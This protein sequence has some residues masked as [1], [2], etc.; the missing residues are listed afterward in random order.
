MP[1][2]NYGLLKAIRAHEISSPRVTDE[3]ARGRPNACNVCH[4]DRSF[5][6]A[7]DALT[8]WYGAPR[9][10]LSE[11]DVRVAAGAR[12]ALEGDAGLRALA[13]WWMGWKAAQEA[14]GS[15]WMLPYVLQL[16]TIPTTRYA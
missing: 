11:D 6:W 13:A 5:A 14:S 1:Y 15:D 3:P 9:P 12:W 10:T 8:A 16:L 7:A 2:T 4:L